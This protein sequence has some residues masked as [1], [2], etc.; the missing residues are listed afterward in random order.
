MTGQVL[1]DSHVAALLDTSVA[2]VNVL[3]DGFER[4]RPYAAPPPHELSAVRFLTADGT[5]TE[6]AQVAY[7]TRTAQ[8]LRSVFEAVDA[9]RMDE[10]ADLLNRL[11]LETGARPQ[12]DQ[13]GGEPWQLHFHGSD[14]SLAMGWS[15]GCASALAL[16]VGS[17]LAGRM[18]VC[19]AIQCDRVYVDSSRNAGRQFCSTACQSRTKAAAFRA[20]QSSIA[21]PSS[22]SRR[23]THGTPAPQQRPK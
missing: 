16:A 21:E 15:A 14:D 12:L 11:L 20:R 23:S 1:F 10:A 13:V 3:T 9:D 22:R 19:Q 8:S 4:G 7:L 6:P 18:G 17:N 5:P 2:L